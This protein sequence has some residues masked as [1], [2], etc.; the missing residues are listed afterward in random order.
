M[1]DVRIML[2][3]R[4]VG[5]IVEIFDMSQVCI[6][7]VKACPLDVRLKYARRVSA[8]AARRDKRRIEEIAVAFLVIDQKGR[9]EDTEAGLIVEVAAIFIVVA[10]YIDAAH[11]DLES[12]SDARTGRRFYVRCR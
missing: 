5:E 1:I 6:E 11:T 4:V 12:R 10:V 3:Q 7:S 9:V 2:I 8:P